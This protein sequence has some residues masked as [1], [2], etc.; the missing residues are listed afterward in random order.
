MTNKEKAVLLLKEWVKYFE[1]GDVKPNFD[2][3]LETHT[4]IYE[5]EKEKS[6]GDKTFEAHIFSYEAILGV[7]KVDIKAGDS[8][9]FKFGNNGIM[10]NEFIKPWDKLSDKEKKEAWKKVIDKYGDFKDPDWNFDKSSH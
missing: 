10:E 6:K 4:F 2:L 3:I 7:F 1:T 5:N 9:K 8:I